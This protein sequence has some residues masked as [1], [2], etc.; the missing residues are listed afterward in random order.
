MGYTYLNSSM[1]KQQNSES[2]STSNLFS[3]ILI[4]ASFRDATQAEA[5]RGWPGVGGLTVLY[6]VQSSSAFPAPP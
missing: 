6:L 4:G 2:I 1:S 5:A 3:G